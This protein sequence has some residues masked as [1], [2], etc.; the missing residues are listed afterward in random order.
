MKYKKNKLLLIITVLVL[1]ITSC[2]G[3]DVYNFS[4]NSQIGYTTKYGNS[5]YNN[6]NPYTNPSNKPR[7]VSGYDAD[8]NYIDDGQ[9]Y[10][11]QDSVHFW[12]G[13]SNGTI[14]YYNGHWYRYNQNNGL[15]TIWSENTKRP[16]H[17]NWHYRTSDPNYYNPFTNG[18]N[19]DDYVTKPY[20]WATPLNDELFVLLLFAI[21]FLIIKYSKQI[22]FKSKL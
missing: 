8:G 7:R 4:N 17:W 13:V 22:K 21:A 9:G 5:I 2:F 19:P 20:Q 1:N 15:W 11:D 14:Y 16:G 6:V 12:Y 10:A 3:N 18:Q